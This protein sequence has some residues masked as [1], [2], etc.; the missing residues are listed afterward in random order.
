MNRLIIIGNGFDL[1]HGLTT[2]YSDFIKNFWNSIKNTDTIENELIEITGS[3]I[4]NIDL[5]NNS[6]DLTIQLDKLSNSNNFGIKYN[7]SYKNNFFKRLERTKNISNWVDIEMEYYK[8]VKNII[9]NKNSIS[10]NK[11]TIFDINREIEIIRLLFEKYLIEIVKPII[12][13]RHL[14]EIENLFNNPITSLNLKQTILREFPNNFVESHLEDYYDS[15]ISSIMGRR[16]DPLKE[17]KR[18]FYETIVLNFNYTNT[19]QQYTKDKHYSQINIHGE[20]GNTNHPINLGFGDEMDSFYSEIEKENEN[21]YLRFIKSFHYTNTNHYKKLFDHLDDE[22]FQV[23]I[24]GHS[25]GLSD[26]TLLNSIFEHKNC[27]SIKVFYH[28]YK[29]VEGILVDNYSDIVKN[30]SRHF[31]KK[32]MMREKIVNKEYCEPLPQIK[33]V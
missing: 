31:N 17:S 14:D 28:E 16:I 29:D 27:K 19:V 8:V 32:P 20:I 21:E 5:I 6:N 1:A 2:Q 26:R 3:V 33:K 24:M 15:A 9:G 12:Q 13:N 22:F 30:I 10:S 18:L 23:Q 11:V 25:C 7:Y 4:K